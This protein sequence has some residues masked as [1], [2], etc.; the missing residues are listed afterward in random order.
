MGVVYKARQVSLNRVV[1]LKMILVG[2]LAF[3]AEVRRFHSEAENAAKLDHP[4]IVPIYEVGE[5]EGLH[6]F[7]MKLIEG[8]SLAQVLSRGQ[9][10][11]EGKE[12]QRRA[13]RLLATAARAVHHA[14][15]RGILHRDLK[16]ANVLL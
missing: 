9:W 3:D 1:A 13:A 8:P 5:H 2:Q 15:Q 6:Y 14:H 11:N 12:A 4:N 16:P 10:P 7:G